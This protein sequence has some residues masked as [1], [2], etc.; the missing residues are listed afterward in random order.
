MSMSDTLGDMLT[1]IR[2]GQTTNKRVVDAPASRFR[3][4]VLEVFKIIKA[5]KISFSVISDYGKVWGSDYD[6]WIVTAGVESRISLMLGNFPLLV[7]SA[8]L[9]QTT[10][11]WSN[12]K[13]FNDIEPY[14]RLALVNPF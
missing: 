3:K 13:S 4:N 5:G 2:N 8:G 12:G 9:A 11:E 10:D 6:D 14:Y 1:R 7:Y